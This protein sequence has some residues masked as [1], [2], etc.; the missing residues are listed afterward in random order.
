MLSSL[1]MGKLCISQVSVLLMENYEPPVFA[2]A[3]NELLASLVG[4]NSTEIPT[5]V[6]PFVVAASKLKLENKNAVSSHKV[7]VYGLQ[8][9]SATEPTDALSSKLQQPPPSLQIF[10][11]QLACFLQFA[12][13]LKFSAF[14]IFGQSGQDISQNSKRDLEVHCL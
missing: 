7:S 5:F 12:R 3:L 10:H 11:E 2:L 6:V 14:V 13:V 1:V 8:F 4:E 9:G